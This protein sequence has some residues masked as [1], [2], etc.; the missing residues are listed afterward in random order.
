MTLPREPPRLQPQHWLSFLV[1]ALAVAAG[2]E[3][4]RKSRWGESCASSG[5]C[6]DDFACFVQACAPAD[7]EHARLTFRGTSYTGRFEGGL[8]AEGLQVAPEGGERSG[9]FKRGLQ[10][11]GAYTW[12]DGRRFDGQFA[13]G[14]IRKGTL[15]NRDGERWAGEFAGGK[16]VNG[17]QSSIAGPIWE[18]RVEDGAI[19][20]G[21]LRLEDG[22]T[23]EGPLWRRQLHGRG[24]RIEPTGRMVA[25]EFVRGEAHGPCVL[26]ESD[27]TWLQGRCVHD[28]L[29][30]P[31][32]VEHPGGERWE[33]VYAAGVPIAGFTTDA[34]GGIA[35]DP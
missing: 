19:V 26:L 15:T 7:G 34:D 10:V 13:D 3:S 17:R 12:K 32:T 9:H 4:P 14:K 6:E 16:L 11:S 29:D 35:F 30:G 24:M 21:R 20:A 18:A 23:I 2:L 33:G 28:A 25:G 22:T 31:V 1:I 8:F 5:D 27:G